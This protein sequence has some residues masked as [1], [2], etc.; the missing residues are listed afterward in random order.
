M[1]KCRSWKMDAQAPSSV[2]QWLEYGVYMDFHTTQVM[3]EHGCFKQ[4]LH[5]IGKQQS[6]DC[7]FN[8]GVPD[9]AE[10]H[11]V[12]RDRWAVQRDRL[13]TLIELPA[14]GGVSPE[15]IVQQ[16]LQRGDRWRHFRV[17]CVETL[18]AKEDYERELRREAWGL[19]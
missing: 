18:S 11:L 16:V 15:E 17:F 10:H 4:Y 9:T 8:C 1:A 6:P 12:E 7:W 19:T 3:S 5:K 2:T 13:L 14:N